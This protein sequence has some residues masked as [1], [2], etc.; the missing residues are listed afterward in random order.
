[1]GLHSRRYDL[2]EIIVLHSII[3]LTIRSKDWQ[4]RKEAFRASHAACTIAPW[5]SLSCRSFGLSP[6]SF[7]RHFRTFNLSKSTPIPPEK[8]FPSSLFSRD[9]VANG[10]RSASA[11]ESASATARQWEGTEDVGVLPDILA[12][13]DR[14]G[15]ADSLVLRRTRSLSLRPLHRRLRLVLFSLH[16]HSRPRRHLDR[17][18]PINSTLEPPWLT[19][20]NNWSTLPNFSLCVDAIA[21]EDFCK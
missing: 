2:Q 9:S 11:S 8:N 21:A 19:K 1:M 17:T 6:F 12:P 18:F 3:K 20:H 4:W 5:P 14:D 7:R 10:N 15:G 13:N 16:H